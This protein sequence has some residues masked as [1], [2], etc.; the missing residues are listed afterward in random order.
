MLH[1]AFLPPTM[2]DTFAHWS[3]LYKSVRD[4]WKNPKLTFPVKIEVLIKLQMENTVER[5]APKKMP[6]FQ[7]SSSRKYL[8]YGLILMSDLRTSKFLL[9]KTTKTF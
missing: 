1:H 7:F 3:R 5:K 9:E 6:R 8:T 4:F 2:S